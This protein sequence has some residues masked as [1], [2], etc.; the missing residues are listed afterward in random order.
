M[1]SENAVTKR[2]YRISEMVRAFGIGRSTI[3][4]LIA[5]GRLETMKSGKITLIPATS[6]DDWERA[7]REE[8][9]KQESFRKGPPNSP[10]T[11]NPSA[12]AKQKN[13]GSQ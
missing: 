12:K 9:R 4:D 2:A 13:I 6:I 1:N 5:K 11:E 10:Y 8:A 7:S 3:Y